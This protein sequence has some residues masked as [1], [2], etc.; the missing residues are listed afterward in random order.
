METNYEGITTRDRKDFSPNEVFVTLNDMV[1]LIRTVRD[2]FNLGP[3]VRLQVFDDGSTALI[4]GL[5]ENLISCFD[6]P[7][8]LETVV[9]AIYKGEEGIY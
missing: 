3:F 5:G 6:T 8:E 4:N 1:A 7:A 2:K 9:E